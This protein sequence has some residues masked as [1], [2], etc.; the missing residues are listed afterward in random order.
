M[1]S[2]DRTKKQ[3]DGSYSLALGSGMVGAVATGL[4]EARRQ[5]YRDNTVQS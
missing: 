3:D 2:R 1:A 5:H 4:S